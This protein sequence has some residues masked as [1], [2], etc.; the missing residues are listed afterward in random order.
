MLVL[1]R[2]MVNTLCRVCGRLTR[3]L[4]I[5]LMPAVAASPNS[6]HGLTL[7]QSSP[8]VT[9]QILGQ[10]QKDETTLQRVRLLSPLATW[11]SEDHKRDDFRILTFEKLDDFK[12]VSLMF[13]KDELVAIYLVP[14]S[15]NR[16]TGED[17]KRNYSDC[18]FTTIANAYPMNS[19]L[20]GLSQDRK[21]IVTGT[22]KG[23]VR[24]EV[25]VGNVLAISI[26]DTA[27]FSAQ[28]GKVNRSLE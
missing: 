18:E 21:V 4:F 5:V 22:V 8:A 17:L 15:K 13:L 26:A 1:S 20:I 28:R 25:L 2:E 3:T 7:R 6:W 23:L 9:V 12:T 11:L 10:P 14:N 24:D 27:V 16:I 19:F